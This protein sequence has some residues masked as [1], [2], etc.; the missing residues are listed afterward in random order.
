MFRL[1]YFELPCPDKLTPDG[2]QNHGPSKDQSYP[3]RGRVE[4]IFLIRVKYSSDL[5]QI[6]ISLEL[7]FFLIEINTFKNEPDYCSRENAHKVK[8]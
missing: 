5:G 4:P 6:C 8:I 3:T 1:T 7:D 2:T